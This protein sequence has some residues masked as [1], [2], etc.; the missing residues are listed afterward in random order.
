MADGPDVE[1]TISNVAQPLFMRPRKAYM[2][3]AGHLS[4]YGNKRSV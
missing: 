3:D 2:G 4:G 1:E